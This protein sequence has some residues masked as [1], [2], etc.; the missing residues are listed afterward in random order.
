VNVRRVRGS[1]NRSAPFHNRAACPM[2]V[3]LAICCWLSAANSQWLETTIDLSPC[4]GVTE[5]SC[6]AFCDR[7][8][9]VWIAGQT[10]GPESGNVA[11]AIDGVTLAPVA[12]AH[13]GAD[14]V[15]A[16]CY[17]R[18]E[19]KLY[20]ANGG[21]FGDRMTLSVIDCSTRAS[22]RTIRVCRDPN[23]LC[24]NPVFNKLYSANWADSL[25]VVDC[26]TDTVVARMCIDGGT[27]DMCYSL[28]TGAVFLANSSANTVTIVGGAT[29]SIVG[30]VTVGSAPTSV[31]AVLGGGK[32]FCANY[33]SSVA[34][35]TISVIDCANNQ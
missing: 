21:W 1:H 27:G 19:N 17:A 24:Y 11:V 32:V 25:A 2:A 4:T 15:N 26:S 23:R 12:K 3:L 18:Q 13:V 16:V 22:V 28:L 10:V 20:F 31:C 8:N 7:D 6:L 9:T 14:V 35:S 30:T 29:D 5:P 33:G 34:D